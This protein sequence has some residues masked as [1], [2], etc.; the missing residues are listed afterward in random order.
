MEGSMRTN[1]SIEHFI[2]RIFTGIPSRF[3]DTTLYL[4]IEQKAWIAN[5]RE[6][7]L[8]MQRS[9]P[10]QEVG[11]AGSRSPDRAVNPTSSVSE[12]IPHLPTHEPCGLL[13]FPGQD[14]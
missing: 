4:Q 5:E 6:A 7:L 9:P 2:N 11:F 10:D 1:P 13:R 8:G 3:H 12:R 14:Q